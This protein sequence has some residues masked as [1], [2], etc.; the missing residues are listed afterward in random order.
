MRSTQSHFPGRP[1]KRLT[2][3]MSV[4]DHVRHTSLQME[5]LKR[6]RKAKLAGATVFEGVEGFGTS[7]RVHR[8]HVISDDR[9]LAI[10]LVDRP[11]RIDAFL[12]SIGPLLDGVAVTVDDVEMLDEWGS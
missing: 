2:L 9:P 12:E 7:G 11:E 4:H 3:L 5:V 6:A 10:V 8:E 1:A